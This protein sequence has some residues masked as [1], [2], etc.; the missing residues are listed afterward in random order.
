[1]STNPTRTRELT[2]RYLS[3]ILH[4][5]RTVHSRG[6]VFGLCPI[7]YEPELSGWHHGD[8]DDAMT[9]ETGREVVARILSRL[10]SVNV[11]CAIQHAPGIERPR[12]GLVLGW[13]VEVAEQRT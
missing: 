3:D 5:C 1:M 9:L 4:D 12:Y 13:T 10:E 8:L 7:G 2:R 11:D 6:V